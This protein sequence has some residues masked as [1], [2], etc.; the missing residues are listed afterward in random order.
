M[1]EMGI[2]TSIFESILDGDKTVEGRL[3][4]AKFVTLRK[5]DKISFRRDVWKNDRLVN[6]ESK[7]AEAT[8]TETKFYESFD[9]MF[10]DIDYKIAAPQA[11]NLQEALSMLNKF[12][13]ADQ[14]AEYGVV[15]IRF[16][17]VA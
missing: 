13:T 1:I 15:A 4:T 12:Y 8:I 7:Q 6:S 3:R 2:E 11:G 5:G 17:L 14:V 16:S 10:A 9:A